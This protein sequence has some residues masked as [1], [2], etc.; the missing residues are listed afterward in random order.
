M[1]NPFKKDRSAQ[2]PDVKMIREQGLVFLKEELQKLE[3]GEGAHVQVITLFIAPPEEQQHLYEAAFYLKDQEKLKQE[4]QRVA[5]N[6]ALELPVNWKLEVIASDRLGQDLIADKSLYL[7]IKIGTTPLKTAPA[8]IEKTAHITVLQGEAERNE[9]LIHRTHGR[10]NLGR[11]SQVQ[12][13]DGSLR[14]NFIA[15]ADE[16][17]YTGNRFVSRKHAHLEW[18]DQ[19]GGFVLFADEGGIPPANK[20]KVRSAADE[21]PLRLNASDVGYLLKEGDQVILGESV[22]LLFKYIEEN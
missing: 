10:V 16:S 1:F 7:A 5:D 13:A 9:Y 12:S 17:G 18:D 2:V 14:L 8:L 11:G 3:G 15:F 21:N 4:I 20:T 22:V 19:K 6:F